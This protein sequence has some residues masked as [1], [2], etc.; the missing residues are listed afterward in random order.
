MS[1]FTANTVL[2]DT[3]LDNV[4]SGNIRLPDFQRGWVWDDERIKNL[5]VS[6]SRGFPVGAV[7][8]LEAGGDV[9][10]QTRLIEG[11]ASNGAGQEAQHYL[12]DGQQRL[13]SLYQALRYKGPVETHASPG[14]GWVEKKWYYIDIQRSLNPSVDRDD[15]IFSVPEDRVVKSNFGHVVELDLSSQDREFKNHMMPTEKVMDGMGWG[16]KYAQ[17]WHTHGGHPHGD[18]FAFFT[19]FKDDVLDN[20][21]LYQLPVINLG[22]STPK[23]A[24][25]TVFEKVNTGGVTL[26][27]FELVTASFAAGDF[28]LRDDWESRKD[29][30]HSKFRVLQ[31]IGGDQ[32]LQAVTLLA[33]QAR[34]RKAVSE[35]K[36]P[37]HV[38]GIGCKRTDILNLELSE[39]KEWADLVEEG[40][41]DAARFLHSQ[42]VFTEW[43]VPYNTQLVPLA[44]LYVE[45]GKELAPY[46]AHQR[47]NRWFWCGV[48]DEVYGRS[49]VYQV[50]LDLPQVACYVRGG[51]EPTLVTQA[52]FVPER[53]LTL[54]TRNSAAYKGLYALQ[55]KSGASDWMTGAKLQHAI[56]EDKNIDIHHIFPVAWC[57]DKDRK[58]PSSLYDSIIN[59]TPIDAT[60]NR[61]IGGRAPSRYLP[62]LRQDITPEKLRQVL[63]THWLDP[64]SLEADK[65]GECFEKR[66]EEMLKLIGEVMGKTISGGSEVFRTAL[67]DGGLPDLEADSL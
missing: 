37:N 38:P 51:P 17:Y 28:R 43:D 32:F 6:I 15:T 54:T 64:D 25:C 8:T 22:K 58:I 65:F 49:N 13:T 20:F 63:K 27:V 3:L 41:K 40:F 53:L 61:L 26:S 10:F 29:R 47:L 56:L 48:F 23:E 24:V 34:Q 11:V 66:G 4:E 14:G 16:F 21:T 59:K 46:N 31:G 9:R 19:R 67:R 1:T 5:L 36:P 2:L 42:F 55:M 33:T 30:L 39:Y 50:A 12:L 52:S 35:E 60:T 62:R 57:V 18:P 45:L 44:A 7:M